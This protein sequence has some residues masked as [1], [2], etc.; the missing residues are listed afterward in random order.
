MNKGEFPSG[1]RGQTVNLLLHAS[2]VRIHPLPPVTGKRL[3]ML[4]GH[5]LLRFTH[6][7]PPIRLQVP[8]PTPVCRR[9]R[10]CGL[11]CFGLSGHILCQYPGKE[12][13]LKKSLDFSEKTGIIE[14][15]QI[16][17]NC[18]MVALRPLTP[19]VGVQIPIPQP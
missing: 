7:P 5:Y 10:P 15:F 1:Q 11:F 2:V 13:F 19:S 8:T 9:G 17:R 6:F 18:V 12:N 14:L 3:L 16:L 4:A